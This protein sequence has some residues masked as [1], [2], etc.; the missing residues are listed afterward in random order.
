ML[1]AQLAVIEKLYKNIGTSNVVYLQLAN[2]DITGT[3]SAPRSKCAKAEAYVMLNNFTF[4]GE[5]M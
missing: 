5:T 1:S 3:G 4:E 2:L